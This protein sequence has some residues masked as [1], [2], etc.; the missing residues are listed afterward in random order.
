MV[1]QCVDSQGIGDGEQNT[2]LYI[3]VAYKGLKKYK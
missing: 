1:I 2:Y 3:N